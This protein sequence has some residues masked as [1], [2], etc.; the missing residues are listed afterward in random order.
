MRTIEELRER[1]E[2]LQQL[3]DTGHP[4]A[5]EAADAQQKKWRDVQMSNLAD[6]VYDSAIHKGT[7]P[8]AG[9]G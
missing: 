4:Q 7:P 3:R 2:F 8:R 6:D 9:L 5:I 1:Q